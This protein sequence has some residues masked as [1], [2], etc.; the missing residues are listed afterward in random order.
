[1]LKQCYDGC[2]V[3]VQALLNLGLGCYSETD[4]S[5]KVQR[6]ISLNSWKRDR[7]FLFWG[8]P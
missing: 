4:L 1:M 3:S 2:L 7:R 6:K 5:V 8:E